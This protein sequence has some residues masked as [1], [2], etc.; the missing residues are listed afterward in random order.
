MSDN[1]EPGSPEDSL[2]DDMPD[3]FQVQQFRQQQKH[4]PAGDKGLWAILDSV[5]RQPSRPEH[6]LDS[7]SPA[8]MS[9]PL[10]SPLPVVPEPVAADEPAPPPQP[11]FVPPPQPAFSADEPA[12]PPQPAF[13]PPPQPAFSASGAGDSGRLFSR[14]R[15]EVLEQPAFVP[16]PQSASS[17]SGAGDTD[18]PYHHQREES[19]APPARESTLF[20]RLFRQQRE[21]PAA[22]PPEESTL[23]S[24]FKRISR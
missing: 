10:T 20:G 12:P 3:D 21:E 11:A 14:Q 19:V 16:P 18:R 5:A 15:D 17:A 13:V 2:K 24:M 23:K 6:S 7:S 22:P 8:D 4:T 9:A 1:R